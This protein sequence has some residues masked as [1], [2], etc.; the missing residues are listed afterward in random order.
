MIGSE[1]EGLYLARAA[2]D[3]GLKVKVLDPHKAFGGQILQSQML[4]LDET[5]D[6]QGHLLAQGRVKE[7]FDGFRNA[8]I[9]KLPEFTAYMNKLMKDIPL[10]SGI[11]INGD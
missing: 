3:E 5:R 10:E 6:D 9:R 1:L 11:V 2:A 7:L 4:F 8:K